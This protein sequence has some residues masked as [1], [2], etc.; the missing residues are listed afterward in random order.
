MSKKHLKEKNFIPQPQYLGGPK[1]MSK[2]VEDQLKYPD[3]A[4]K[5][6]IEGTVVVRIEINYLGE[7]VNAHIISGLGHGCDQEAVRVVKLL[8]FKIAKIHQLKVSFFKTINIGFQLPRQ[9][10]MTINYQIIPEEKKENKSYK[11]PVTYSYK[12]QI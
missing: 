4:I 3:E 1:A 9:K 6:Q 8:K 7:V 2:F 12:I 5:N 10:E 11:P